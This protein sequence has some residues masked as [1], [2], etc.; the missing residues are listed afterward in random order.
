MKRCCETKCA[1]VCIRA[2]ALKRVLQGWHSY[3]R[4]NYV[5]SIFSAIKFVFRNQK[6]SYM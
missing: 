6:L 2:S 5:A 4:L 1:S 3:G